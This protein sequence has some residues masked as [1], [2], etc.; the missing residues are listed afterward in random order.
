MSY[1]QASLIQ[2][3]KDHALVIDCPPELVCAVCEQESNWNPYALRAEPAFE[4]RYIKPLHLTPT[5]DWARSFS[6][7]LMQIMGETARELGYT[8]PLPALCVPD[9]G[10]YYGCRKLSACLA[11]HS[12]DLKAALLAYNGGGDPTYP[13]KVIARM[14]KYKTP[15]NADDVREAVI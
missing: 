12:P 6:W 9:T 5:E 3:A 1:T 15:N 8:G 14:S 13:D 4:E 10:L 7:G 11:K 2:A